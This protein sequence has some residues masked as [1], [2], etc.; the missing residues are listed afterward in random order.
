MV[1]FT[2]EPSV[3]MAGVGGSKG[4]LVKDQTFPFFWT[5]G[6]YVNVSNIILCIMIVFAFLNRES[7]LKGGYRKFVLFFHRSCGT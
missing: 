1:F 2:A 7:I 6:I 5:I 3:S 4:G